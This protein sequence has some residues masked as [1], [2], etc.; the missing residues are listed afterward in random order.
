MTSGPR[1]VRQSSGQPVGGIV[2]KAPLNPGRGRR[3]QGAISSSPAPSGTIGPYCNLA[4][5]Q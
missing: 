5:G 3:P 1:R 2:L 4:E